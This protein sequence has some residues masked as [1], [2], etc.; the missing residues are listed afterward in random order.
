MTTYVRYEIATGEIDCCGFTLTEILPFD[1]PT[2]FASLEGYG[3][4][5]THYVDNGEI[6]EYTSSQQTTKANK[7]TY[8]CSWSNTLFV[9]V[10]DRTTEEQ[11]TEAEN[12]V[13]ATRD[14]LLSGTDWIV[15][16]AVD[17][18]TPIPVDWQTYRQSLRD[19]TKQSGYPTNVVWPVAPN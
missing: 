1:V 10:D 16:R 19:I 14:A 12:S 5:Q 18:G 6:L 4:N 13:I 17:Q 7:P 3:A 11:N 15:V 2:G 9:W 8:E